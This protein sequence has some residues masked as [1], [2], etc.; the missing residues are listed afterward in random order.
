MPPKILFSILLLSA[1]MLIFKVIGRTGLT[2]AYEKFEDVKS[3]SNEE[4]ALKEALSARVGIGFTPFLVSTQIIA[5]RNLLFAGNLSSATYRPVVRP[6]M[7]NVYVP[8]AGKPHITEIKNIY[9]L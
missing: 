5:G 8:I 6:V 9:D 7:I 1:F 3:G 2:R 4:T